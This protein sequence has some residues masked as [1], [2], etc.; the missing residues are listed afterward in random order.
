MGASSRPRDRRSAPVARDVSGL[1]RGPASPRQAAQQRGPGSRC[2]RFEVRCGDGRQRSALRVP[3]PEVP[4]RC[5]R[6]PPGSRAARVGRRLI[7]EPSQSMAVSGMFPWPAACTGRRAGGGLGGVPFGAA[8]RLEGRRL[9][10]QG[11]GTGSFSVQAHGTPP[12]R[13][14]Y[15]ARSVVPDPGRY[16]ALDA[17]RGA[18]AAMLAP[19][20]SPSGRLDPKNDALIS[21]RALT[22]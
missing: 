9:V 4:D 20:A 15:H 1:R 18:R 21:S 8:P 5:H 3:L 12:C 11:A 7:D 13:A 16:P 22:E 2:D 14:R 17:M 10:N 6:D 19:R